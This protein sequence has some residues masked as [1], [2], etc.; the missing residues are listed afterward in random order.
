MPNVEPL[1]AELAEGN[2]LSAVLNHIDRTHTGGKTA[3]DGGICSVCS[4][5]A[6]P[7]R[8]VLGPADVDPRRGTV[9]MPLAVR[10]WLHEWPAQEQQSIV[11]GRN[12][13]LA[14][15]AKTYPRGPKLANE[16]QGRPLSGTIIWDDCQCGS[17]HVEPIVPRHWL[18]RYAPELLWS[19]EPRAKRREVHRGG[20]PDGGRDAVCESADDG[21][22]EEGW[23]AR[24]RH[25]RW[26][27]RLEQ[28]SKAGYRY[29]RRWARDRN[30][31]LERSKGGPK[32]PANWRRFDPAILT[33]EGR[34]KW[35]GE[36][37]LDSW[38]GDP[39]RRDDEVPITRDKG[40]LD[41]LAWARKVRVHKAD[42]LLSLKR[43]R[44]RAEANVEQYLSRNATPVEAALKRLG[45][46]V[47][48][49]IAR[50]LDWTM[51]KADVQAAMPKHIIVELARREPE[52]Y[53]VLADIEADGATEI[54]DFLIDALEGIVERI[55]RGVGASFPCELRAALRGEPGDGKRVIEA[56]AACGSG[57]RTATLKKNFTACRAKSNVTLRK[58]GLLSEY[59]PA[60][61][62]VTLIG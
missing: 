26:R 38:L 50:P 45:P 10:R 56:A 61:P 13:R 27:Q 55:G 58:H 25:P 46:A 3:T 8:E 18:L 9:A 20:Y 24:L 51:R 16:F 40:D 32:Q 11:A 47:R 39:T 28:H 12:L 1:T 29:L 31:R 4:A 36:R 17:L 54:P 14:A 21:A 15:T 22:V 2:E 37:Q 62:V 5:A 48:R 6:E 52:A 43:T 34:A 7:T 23:S 57:V 53:A 44:Q 19:E 35:D 59:L 41:R 49:T 42:R 60:R 33:P 30:P